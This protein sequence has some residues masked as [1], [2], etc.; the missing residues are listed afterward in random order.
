[1]VKLSL[2]CI[3]LISAVLLFALSGDWLAASAEDIMTGARPGFK[4]FLF[5]FYTLFSFFSGIAGTI[6]FAVALFRHL[7][8]MSI[9][10]H[11]PEELF[12]IGVDEN[13]IVVNSEETARQI[14]EAEQLKLDVCFRQDRRK[15]DWS[16]IEAAFFE[17]ILDDRRHRVDE[18]LKM[19]TR[20]CFCVVTAKRGRVPRI[21]YYDGAYELRQVHDIRSRDLQ[22]KSLPDFMNDDQLACDPRLSSPHPEVDVRRCFQTW[23]KTT[24]LRSPTKHTV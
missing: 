22:D 14:K 6:V 3:A 15:L 10:A 11:T 2:L 20:P 24:S 4:A 9:T 5:G 8:G 16:F 18:N 17:R 21:Q 12:L 19:H 13:G 23:I 1:M 7:A